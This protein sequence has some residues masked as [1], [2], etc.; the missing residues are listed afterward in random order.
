MGRGIWRDREAVNVSGALQRRFTGR[1]HASL[2]G[3]Y[4]WIDYK[5][6]AKYAPLYGWSQYSGGLEVGYAAGA[7]TDFLIAGGFSSYHHNKSSGY[8]NYSNDSESWTIQG[9]IGTHATK[10]ITYRVLMGASWLS[11]GGRSNIDSGWTYSLSSN[12][13]LHRQWQISASGQSYY[14]PSER[15]LGR[16][17]KVQSLSAGV[18][19]LTLGDKLRLAFDIAFRYE[20]TVYNDEIVSR[21][22]DYHETIYSARLSANYTLNRWV[23]LF[24]NIMW[25][26]NTSDNI[27]Y[28]YDRFRGTLGVRFHY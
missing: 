14:Q 2:S 5:N 24:A 1:W 20:D 27:Y 7:W 9:G 18:S 28:E 19:Y 15:T 3:Q 13:R 8:Y 17:M 6:S 10:N 11:Y 16:A 25:E 21:G 22:L 12:W 4:D 26:D 23:S